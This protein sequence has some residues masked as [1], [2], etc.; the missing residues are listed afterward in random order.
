MLQSDI[1]R[2]T[3][4]IQSEYNRGLRVEGQKS[5]IIQTQYYIKS[6]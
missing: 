4:L 1:L 6:S 5:D 3:K 2:Y